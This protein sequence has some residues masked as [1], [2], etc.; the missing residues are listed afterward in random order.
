MDMMLLKHQEASLRALIEYPQIPYVFLIGG[1]GCGKSTSVVAVCLYLYHAYCS[2]QEHITIGILGVTIKLLKQTVIA[3][4]ERAFDSSGI[5]YRDNSQAGTIT[6]GSITFVYLAMGDPDA[7]YAFN[8]HAALCDEID[9]VPP[10]RVKKIV[11]AIQERCRVNMPA[12]RD[13]PARPPFIYFSTTAQGLGGTYQLTKYM[14]KQHLPYIK[15]RGRTEDNTHLSK[16]QLDL[17]RKLYT[18]DERKAFLE[19]EFINL[20]NGRVYPE[21]DMRK[22]RYMNIDV[23]PDDTIYIGADYNAGFNMNVAMIVRTTQPDGMDEDVQRVFAVDEFHWDYMGAAPAGL[24]QKYPTNE[25]VFIPDASGKEIMSGFTEEFDS[26]NINVY[27]N[28]ANP[29]VSER[30][31]AVNRLLRRGQLVV[32]ERCERLLNALETRDFDDNTGAPRKGAGIDAPDHIADSLEYG[33]WRIIHGIQGFQDVL[34][35]I[36][37]VHHHTEILRP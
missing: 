35:A 5:P 32:C 29:S 36:R 30:I 21:F 27:W 31:L 3:D 1:Y 37:A 20:T 18:E 10:E 16:Q 26:A 17:L 23:R 8:F 25:I 28:K 19:G 15:I 12:G 34:D 11:T 22:H 2:S 14:D 4:L 7:I 6:A 33:I 13:W 24:R 9:E